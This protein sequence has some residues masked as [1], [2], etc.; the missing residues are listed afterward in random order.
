MQWVYGKLCLSATRWCA[1]R[2]SFCRCTFC[3]RR[4]CAAFPIARRI[5]FTK[6][7][8]AFALS[9]VAFLH[10][11]FLFSRAVGVHFALRV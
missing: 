11:V 10:A 5:F 4:A 6:Q 3:V 2:P 1:N 9:R 7:H 8:V